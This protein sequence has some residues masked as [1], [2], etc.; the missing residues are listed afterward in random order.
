MVKC[1]NIVE[2]M[3]EDEIKN[4]YDKAIS[5]ITQPR[6][7][8]WTYLTK[9]TYYGTIVQNHVLLLYTNAVHSEHNFKLNRNLYFSLLY[10]F[11]A[12]YW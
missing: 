8:L 5:S 2:R 3:S 9:I 6:V 10:I 1:I 12:Y 7:N 11:I 4:K